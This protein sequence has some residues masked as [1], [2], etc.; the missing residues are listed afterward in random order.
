MNKTSNLISKLTASGN[1][2]VKKNKKYS[3]KINEN[4]QR[5]VDTIND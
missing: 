4:I 5:T 2:K 3:N 1:A